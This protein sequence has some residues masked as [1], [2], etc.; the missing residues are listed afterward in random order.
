VSKTT[1]DTM[2]SVIL[3][4]YLTFTRHKTSIAASLFRYYPYD[5]FSYVISTT[6]INSLRYVS[7]SISKL[8]EH[9][10]TGRQ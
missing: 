9:R 6:V 2:T 5:G 8:V 1:N 10:P 4:H 7:A 3:T